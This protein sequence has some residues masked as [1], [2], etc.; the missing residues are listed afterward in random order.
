MKSE[1]GDPVKKYMVWLMILCMVCSFVLSSCASANV[2]KTAAADEIVENKK[3]EQPAEEPVTEEKT[4]N[5][6]AA[7]KP[8]EKPVEEQEEPSAEEKTEQKQEKKTDTEK[9][10]PSVEHSYVYEERYKTDA[11]P[12]KMQ[13][14]ASLVIKGKPIK[15]ISERMTNPDE[16]IKTEYGTL[17]N[18]NVTEYEFEIIEIIKGTYEGKTISVKFFEE[19]ERELVSFVAADPA[20]ST[21]ATVRVVAKRPD[22][23]DGKEYLLCI[24]DQNEIAFPE[25]THG[26][27][28]LNYYTGIDQIEGCLEADENGDFT[29]FHVPGETVSYED[30]EGNPIE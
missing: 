27:R 13:Q 5:K 9:D 14:D 10:A 18:N 30:Q 22:L 11:T 24:T 4:E 7:P 15:K 1:R 2:E 19:V 23:V 21:P 8:E 29:K 16:S 20:P 6:P 26:Y 28:V 17:I 3:E 25:W 12:E